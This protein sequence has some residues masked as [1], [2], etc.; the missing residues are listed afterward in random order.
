MM[1]MMMMTDTTAYGISF[2]CLI[3]PVL[4]YM[5]MIVMYISKDLR[6]SRHGGYPQR[7][8]VGWVAS[9]A[10]LHLPEEEG[11]YLDLA[12][13]EGSSGGPSL[14]GMWWS[15]AQGAVK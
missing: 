13:E 7:D 14:T 3:L 11:K 5:I 10:C 12:S 2:H 4:P 8:G 6:A 9:Y 1:M 15:P